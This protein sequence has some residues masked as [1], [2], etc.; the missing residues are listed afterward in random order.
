[1]TAAIA[2]AVVGTLV[3]LMPP[4]PF[5]GGPYLPPRHGQVPSEP[6]DLVS[7]D[8]ACA[9]PTP[10]PGPPGEVPRLYRCVWT[11]V[12]PARLVAQED[13]QGQPHNL[14]I[15]EF[16]ECFGSK[17]CEYSD[18]ETVEETV[19][20]SGGFSA[21]LQAQ[22][23]MAGLR[24]L[25]LG[26]APTVEFRTG[27]ELT[28]S[29]TSTVSL[30]CTVT[31]APCRIVATTYYLHQKR[32][33]AEVPLGHKW[34]SSEYRNGRWSQ[35]QHAG[36]CEGEMGVATVTGSAGWLSGCKSQGSQCPNCDCPPGTRRPGPDAW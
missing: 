7:G 3:L 26:I 31:A 11:T 29:R 2:Q 17:T 27:V 20:A 23:N 1:M 25:G 35:W 36:T 10:P 33:R 28:I 13:E 5:D 4:P 32:A 9:Q 18:S 12:G 34:V 19:S 24:A 14:G 21:G 15:C 30:R 22:I 16:C 6:P 8:C